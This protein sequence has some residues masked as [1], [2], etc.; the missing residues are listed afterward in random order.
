MYIHFEAAVVV[1]VAVAVVVIVVVIVVI[2]VG[3]VVFGSRSV[4]VAGHVSY[5]LEIICFQVVMDDRDLNVHFLTEILHRHHRVVD[6]LGIAQQ[7]SRLFRGE[8]G[9]GV[10]AAFVYNTRSHHDSRLQ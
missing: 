8:S 4:V 5:Y 7:F 1:V 10:L 3:V 9:V 2:V 6:Y